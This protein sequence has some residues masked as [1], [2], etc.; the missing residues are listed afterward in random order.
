MFRISYHPLYNHPVPEHHRFPM[1]KYDLIP[2]QLLYEGTITP[3]QL[4]QPEFAKMDQLL[5]V[6]D[7]EYIQKILRCQLSPSE[8]RKTGFK[9]SERLVQRELSIIQGT[10]DAAHFALQDGVA[11][12]IAGGTHHAFS[13]RGEGFCLFNDNAVAAA[14]LLQHN[15]TRKILIVDLDVHQGNGT[16]QIFNNQ[17]NVYTFSMHGHHNYPFHKEKSDWDIPLEDGTTDEIYLPLLEEAMTT[18]LQTFQPD[19]IFYQAGVDILA[20]DKMGKLAC[21]LQGCKRRD[22][23]VISKAQKYGIPLVIDLGGGYA[24]NIRDIVEAHANTFRVAMELFGY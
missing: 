15:D 14:Y 13:D 23:I 3:A 4:H 19:F 1:E 10:I 20:M 11:F 17:P 2:E 6:H 5:S 12:N 22:E 9:M 24:T 16:A 18:L 8:E 21:T 7:A